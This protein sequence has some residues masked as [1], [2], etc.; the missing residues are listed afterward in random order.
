MIWFVK[1][2]LYYSITVKI[3]ANCKDMVL[4]KLKTRVIAALKFDA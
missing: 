3:V 4:N 1:I 2:T